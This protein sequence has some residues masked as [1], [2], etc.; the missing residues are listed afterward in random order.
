MSLLSFL[1]FTF[2]CL[3]LASFCPLLFCVFFICCSYLFFTS[4][5]TLILATFFPHS[6]SLVCHPVLFLICYIVFSILLPFIY[7]NFLTLYNTFYFNEHII[8]NC[9]T[10]FQV[11]ISEI[12][13]KENKRFF[14][15]YH[16]N[17]IK[18]QNCRLMIWIFSCHF[19]SQ[20]CIHFSHRLQLSCCSVADI[21]RLPL[22]AFLGYN[23]LKT[24]FLMVR[25][26]F[27]EPLKVKQILHF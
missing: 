5:S 27:S 1:V 17:F 19:L 6:C 7:F 23:I 8:R 13:H 26:Q 24:L 16:L 10:M 2:I 11:C 14:D 9:I 25:R 22:P 20:C 18:H 4:W 3:P 21:P 12:E 15:V